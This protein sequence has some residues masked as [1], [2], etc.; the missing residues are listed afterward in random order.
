MQ[1]ILSGLNSVQAEIVKDTE[2]QVLVLAG[3]GSGKALKNGSKVQTPNGPVPIESLKI[4]DSVFNI[5]GGISKIT[6]VFPQ[7]KKEVWK[8]EFSDGVIVECCKDHLWT[9]QTSSQRG[10]KAAYKTT[11]LEEISKLPL[12]TNAGDYERWNLYI[13][14]T[15]AVAYPEK[16]FLISPYLLS[17]LIGDGC[18]RS[19]TFSF[20]N[21]ED[22]LLEK[23]NSE[24]QSIGYALKH[25][26]DYDYSIRMI[27][28]KKVSPLRLELEKLGLSS[29]R[30]YEKF[31]PRD[32]LQS[33]IEQR[34]N[35]LKGL[36]DTDGECCGSYYCYSTTSKQLC[37]DIVELVQSLGMT[38]SVENR[39]TYFT[40]NDE[41]KPGLP[42]YRI[43]IKASGE[44]PKIHS[45]LKHES[46]WVKGQSSARR[47]IRR[48][49]PTSEMADMT[50][51]KVDAEDEL[52]LTEGYVVTHNTRVLTHR[53]AYLIQNNVP[54]WQI[55]AVTFTNKAAREMKER[56]TN[57][58]GA[59][60]RGAWIGTFHGVC[61]RILGRFS[62]E[63]G[64][65]KFT[66]IDDKEQQKVL[67]EV[68]NVLGLE[69]DAQK[70]SS[71]IGDLKN[72]LQTPSMQLQ[73]AQYQ[74]E[75]DVAQ[76]YQA[77]E[78]K[79]A[80]HGYFDFD[81]LIMKTV[82]LFNVSEKARD[83][84]QKQFRY[85]LT[86][87]TQDTNKAQF[88]LLTQLT[89][90][91]QNL[92]AVG[93]TDQCQPPETIISTP[94]GDK[95]IDELKNGDEVLSWN[96]KSQYVTSTGYPIEVASR[97]YKGNM[98]TIH[99]HGKKTRATPNH[100]FLVRWD[101]RDTNIWVTYLMY[102]EDRG[103]R[104]GW[105]QLFN[106]EG[107]FHLGTRVRLEKAD[108]VWILQVHDSKQYATMYESIISIRYGIPTAMFE[109]NGEL[110][111]EEVTS[112]IFLEATR[113]NGEKCLEAHQKYFDYP[114]YPY[115]NQRDKAGRPT[116]FE[117]YAANLLPGFMS[118]PLPGSKHELN[119]WAPIALMRV[120]EYE[121][122][123]YSLDVAEHHNYVADGLVTLNSIYKWRG[124]QIENIINF[125][126]YFPET[127]VYRLEQN[128]R[129]TQ[130][131]V[132]ASNALILNNKERLEK[133]AFSEGPVGLPI[134]IKQAED[135]SREADF[136][137]DIIRL[138]VQKEGRNYNE[139]AVLY[140]TNRQS[141]EIEKSFAQVGI[142]YQIV[143]G[144]AFY[145]RKEIKDIIAYLRAISNGVD[146][147][148]FERII[149]VPRRGVGDTTIAKIQDYANDCMIP[150]PKA[151]EHIEDIPKLTKKAK[152]SIEDFKTIINDLRTYAD[153]EDFYVAELINRILN[154]TGYKTMLQESG[155]EE[156]ESR[157]EN[158]EELIN[159]AGKWDAD[160]D[161]AGKTLSDFLCETSLVADVDGLE[162]EDSRVVLMTGH[163]S[164]GLEFPVVFMIGLEEGIF[165]H[166]NSFSSDSDIEEERR[167]AYVAMTRA[168]SKLYISHCQRRYDYGSQTAIPCKPSRFLRELPRELV[169]RI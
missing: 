121:G 86:D 38:A 16:D 5:N 106:S 134:V 17:A 157:L 43:L 107:T 92:F 83:T 117:C 14:M 162:D 108:K 4:G 147:I 18:L 66:I 97:P 35:L 144:H 169:K 10:K 93:D 98:F 112:Q 105:C 76:I 136:V 23:I 109:P 120:N 8:V 118:I 101:N 128:Y 138:T 54:A 6:G 33:S 37:E 45:S 96:R 47:T 60:S 126:Q 36:I 104:V 102:R 1:D 142:P 111:T 163:S 129:S 89:A 84:F 64:V 116:Y 159:V 74:H 90:H 24:L 44:I 50:C 143:G 15:Q 12:Q 62:S 113:R 46:K 26:S 34:I 61:L 155:K 19:K 130:T 87:E 70:V 151:L 48:I 7:G 135:D 20:S 94:N 51:I 137:R 79:K 132:N 139:F 160:E 39:Q 9:Y 59:K 103:Y 158:L 164:K 2:G 100:K 119:Q 140:R 122:L 156:D 81:D 40:Y 125:T 58:S 123:V 99:A 65:E 85:V 25:R 28:Q 152:A 149:N 153:S 69:Y 77:Y 127:K 78:D 166:R 21:S 73:V 75:K 71:I 141:R 161:N 30:S 3:A 55:L 31:I 154:V 32:Y 114:F 63:I 56:L 11:T 165:P 72:N 67:K 148:A 82:H 80:E 29:S 145:D 68:M 42:S 146:Y 52:F 41:K 95:R 133:T 110:Y 53:I 168:E 27:D 91:H 131:I 88:Q 13:P 22:D 124:A 49:T 57:I 150:F 167:L 115:P